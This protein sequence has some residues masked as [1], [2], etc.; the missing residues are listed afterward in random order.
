[1]SDKQYKLEY[2]Q[3]VAGYSGDLPEHWAHRV[4]VYDTMGEAM[5]HLRGLHAYIE[6]QAETHPG[7]DWIRNVSSLMQ[8]DITYSE[9]RDT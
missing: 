5:A 7:D 3:R 8:R 9:W 6:Q 2:D 4:E 1:M